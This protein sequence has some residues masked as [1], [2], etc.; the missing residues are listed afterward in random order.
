MG[1]LDNEMIEKLIAKAHEMQGMSYVP[2]MAFA[3]GAA[4]LTKDGKI[5]GG[6]NIQ[7]V[8]FTPN[9][10][11]ERV[12]FFKAISEGERDFRAIAI[13]GGKNREIGDMCYPCGVCR[14]VMA[15]FCEPDF[16]IVVRDSAGNTEIRTLAELF[17]CSFGLKP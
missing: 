8:A 4:L 12:A 3:V 11:A 5:Y 6:C 13:V 15:E 14:Q 9:I 17:P 10:C 7:N 16:E 1:N 2:Y